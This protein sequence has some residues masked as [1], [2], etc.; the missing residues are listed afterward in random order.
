M[1]NLSK[2]YNGNSD[3]FQSLEE[4]FLK[5]V[6]TLIYSALNYD[7]MGENKD[8]TEGFVD[9]YAPLQIPNCKTST[10]PEVQAKWSILGNEASV[11]LIFENY[12]I[13]ERF[14]RF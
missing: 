6:L 12:L 10:K 4:E 1:N 14:L 2:N 3:S 5:T 13:S 8:L 9:E 7:F 11:N